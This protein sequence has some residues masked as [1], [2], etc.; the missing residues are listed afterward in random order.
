[1][2]FSIALT[3]LVTPLALL[4]AAALTVVNAEE[5]VWRQRCCNAFG[6]RY[7]RQERVRNYRP[8]VYAYERRYDEDEMAGRSCKDLR[9]AVGDQHITVDGAKKAANDAWAGTVR[10][11]IGEKWMDLNN[12][13]H[14]VYTC[15]RSSIKEQGASVTTLGQALNRCELQAQPCAPLPEHERREE[16]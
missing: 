16:R 7:W 4:P 8:P 12:A 3:V 11:H 13:R 5:L 2:R 9:K 15:S 14:L 6:Y 1:M 10:F